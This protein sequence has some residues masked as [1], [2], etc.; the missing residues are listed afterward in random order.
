MQTC[1]STFADVVN[2]ALRDV[3]FKVEFVYMYVGITAPFIV[4]Q[5]PTFQMPT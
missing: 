5:P 3:M 2:C 4:T 1:S